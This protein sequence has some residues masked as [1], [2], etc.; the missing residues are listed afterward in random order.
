[1]LVWL[2]SLCLLP[3][4]VSIFLNADPLISRHSGVDFKLKWLFVHRPGGLE[5]GLVIFFFLLH[6]STHALVCILLRQ[7]FPCGYEF[8]QQQHGGENIT[9]LSPTTHRPHVLDTRIPIF[10]QLENARC[11]CILIYLEER[12]EGFCY[13]SI[14]GGLQGFEKSINI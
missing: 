7:Y 8:L 14:V 12:V 10:H 2:L 13:Y 6:L 1:M 3:A 5:I 11:S 4:R 9:L